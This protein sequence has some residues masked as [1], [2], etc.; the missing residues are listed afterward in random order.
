MLNQLLKNLELYKV[1]DTSRNWTRKDEEYSY[2]NE[3]VSVIRIASSNKWTKDPTHNYMLK[4]WSIVVDIKKDFT[5]LEN[6]IKLKK[7]ID[8]DITPVRKGKYKGYQ[9]IRLYEMTKEPDIQIVS[10]ILNY[11]FKGV[12]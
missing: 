12:L 9:G 2:N 5:N 6:Y 7:A 4:M 11:I 3:Y 1:K 8:I 10:E